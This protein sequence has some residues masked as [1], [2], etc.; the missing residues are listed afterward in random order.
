M[1]VTPSNPE[2]EIKKVLKTTSG[3][4]K[5]VTMNRETLFNGKRVVIFGLPGAFTPTCST[6]Q[7]PGYEKLYYDFREAGIDDIYCFTV[8]DSFI[9]NEWAIDQGN[10]NVKIIPDGS[11]EFTI[12][13]GMDVRKDNIGFGVRSWRYAAVVDNCE[14]I[15]QFVEEGF[16]DNAEGDPY[17]VSSSENVLDNVKAYGWTS[18]EETEGKHINLTFSDTTDVKEKFS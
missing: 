6:Q 15:Q 8:N 3:D 2:F 18:K 14:V 1:N 16:Q 7:L 17:D 10:V 13:M 12:K 9:C 5:W 4:T 11:A